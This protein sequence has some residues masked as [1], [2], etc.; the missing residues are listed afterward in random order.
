MN[1]A[2]Y[3]F[4]NSCISLEQVVPVGATEFRT[5]TGLSPVFRKKKKKHRSLEIRQFSPSLRSRTPNH[6]YDGCILY[7][8]THYYYPSHCG[9]IALFLG[10][11]GKVA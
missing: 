3:L 1:D 6:R 9:F 4:A 10:K 11:S 2:E 7:V 8:S 5:G